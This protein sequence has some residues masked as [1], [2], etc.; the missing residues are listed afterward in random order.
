MISVAHPMREGKKYYSGEDE[1]V[2]EYSNDASGGARESFWSESI[3][4][5]GITSGFA[6]KCLDATCEKMWGRMGLRDVGLSDS[7]ASVW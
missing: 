7:G 4:S 6:N 5:V 3:A 2:L 1:S